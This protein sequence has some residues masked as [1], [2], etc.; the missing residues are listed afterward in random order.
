M[1]KR[2]LVQHENKNLQA[3]TSE[4]PA[5][6]KSI[7]LEGLDEEQKQLALDLLIEEQESFAKN[8]DDIGVIPDL[9]LDINLADKTPVQKNYVTVPRPLYPEVKSYIEDLLN[10]QFIRKSKSPYSSPV[11]CVQKKDQSLRLCVDY[12]T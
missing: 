7:D 12:R 10:H 6:L 8:D 4:I 2:K 3:A 9:K 5:H 1:A 11:V